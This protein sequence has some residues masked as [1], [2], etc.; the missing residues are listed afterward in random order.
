MK[1]NKSHQMKRTKLT[2]ALFSKMST[3]NANGWQ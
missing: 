3:I 1:R 2:L